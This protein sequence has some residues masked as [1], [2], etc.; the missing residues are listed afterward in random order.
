MTLDLS[1]DLINPDVYLDI[2]GSALLSEKIIAVIKP[3]AF[4][5]HPFA[6]TISPRAVHYACA[7]IK[8]NADTFLFDN[9]QCVNVADQFTSLTPYPNPANAELI[10]EWINQGDEPMQV[11]IYSSSGQ[12]VLSREYSTTLHGLNQVNVNV[13]S[14]QAGI[15][16]AS[17]S[18]GGLPQ[19]FRFSIIR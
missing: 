18:A 8:I 14:L 11:I 17:Y 13:S 10:L 15:Y 4:F 5:T 3:G 9:R 16:F 6:T 12:V 1:Y 19:N 2:S 7:E